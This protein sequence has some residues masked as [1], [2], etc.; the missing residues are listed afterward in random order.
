MVQPVESINGLLSRALIVP[1]QDN[2]RE[3]AHAGIPRRNVFALQADQLQTRAIAKGFFRADD[4][5]PR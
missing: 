4:A 1:P 3:G 5:L 2:K